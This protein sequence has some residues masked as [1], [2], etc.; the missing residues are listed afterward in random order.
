MAGG[1]GSCCLNQNAVFLTADFFDVPQKSLACNFYLFHSILQLPVQLFFP[2]AWN[3]P[4]PAG[5]PLAQGK[6]QDI[7]LS[8]I[9]TV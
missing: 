1:G 2:F 4:P 5:Y 7:P 9:P 6:Y 8:T 3:M